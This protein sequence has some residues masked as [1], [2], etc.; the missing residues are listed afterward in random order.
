VGQYV[1]IDNAV[2]SDKRLSWGA[3][4]LMGYLLSRPD[5]WQMRLYDLVA[6]GP[7]GQQKIRRLISELKTAGYVVRR[8]I[9]RRNGTFDWET[10]IYERPGMG[11]LRTGLEQE[12]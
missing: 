1:R 7:E 9:V 2:F 4:G 10:T 5:T 11:P 6:H 12:L 3:R 8:R